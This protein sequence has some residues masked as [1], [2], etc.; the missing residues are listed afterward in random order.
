MATLDSGSRQSQLIQLLALHRSGLSAG[1]L[2]ISLKMAHHRYEDDSLST[3]YVRT[4]VWGIRQQAREKTGWEGII[5][6]PIKRGSGF[7]RYQ[8]PDSTV[9]DLWE[10]DDLLDRADSLVAPARGGAAFSRPAMPG[11]SQRP[12]EQERAR[13]AAEEAAVWREEALQLYEGEFCEGSTN[14]SLVDAARVLE[15]RYKQAA[16]KQGDYWRARAESVEGS[17]ATCASPVH[18]STAT[19]RPERLHA[20]PHSSTS[21]EARVVWREALHNYERVLDVDGYHE[22]ACRRAMECYARLGDARGVGVVFN[23][24]RS[25][26]QRDLS[27][28]PEGALVRAYEAC[29]ALAGCGRGVSAGTRYRS[30]R[31]REAV[32]SQ[33]DEESG[34]D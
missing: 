13:S 24:Y 32:K 21:A 26:L 31:A 30:S 6:S 33:T 27:Q 4:L 1:Q 17:E 25:T 15:E 28:R 12:P 5:V 18:A 22:E 7:H 16:L 19:T 11:G 2:A 29:K 8:L 10:F 20:A 3:H 23:R 34:Y 9:C 14:G